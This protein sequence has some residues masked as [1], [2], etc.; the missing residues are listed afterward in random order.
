MP[1]TLEVP[2][3][4]RKSKLHS[5]HVEVVPTSPGSGIYSTSHARQYPDYGV[6][7]N[8][9]LHYTMPIQKGQNLHSCFVSKIYQRRLPEEIWG[10]YGLIRA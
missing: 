1:C 7:R 10:F 5:Q 4:K 2:E 8:G 3:P 9:K 6:Q